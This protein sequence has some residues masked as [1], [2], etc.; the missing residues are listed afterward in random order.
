MSELVI[1]SRFCG[2]PSSGNGGWSA[3]ALAAVLT[4][5]ADG[6][7]PTIEVTLRQPPP[8]DE[9]MPVVDGVATD[10]SGAPVAQAR[11]V[12][13][14][15]TPP[16]YVDPATAEE[17][18]AR[19][20]GWDHHPFPTCFSCGTAREDGLRIFPGPTGE[21]SVAATWT[22]RAD[23]ISDYHV[24]E[25]PQPCASLASTWSALDCA[26]AWASDFGERLIVL[27]RITAHVLALPEIGR[28]HVV[29]GESREQTGR[30]SFAATAI[31][32]EDGTLVAAAE[33]VWI[34][35]ESADFAAV[36]PA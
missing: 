8:L 24:Y 22:P 7:W 26:G 23:V 2:P 10:S 17:A 3:G 5:H 15:P 34:S 27:G 28:R 21:H 9:P 14:E 18:S 4:P 35:V 1:P 31:Y 11:D 12:D 36:T 29:V 32:T 13:G 16:A 20:P 25:D 6:T 30:K 19:Y 33:Q